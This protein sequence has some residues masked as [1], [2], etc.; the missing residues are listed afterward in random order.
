MDKMY[1]DR[2][3]AKKKMLESQALLEEV[4]RRLKD[5]QW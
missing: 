3:I 1:N 4:N 2:V 5:E